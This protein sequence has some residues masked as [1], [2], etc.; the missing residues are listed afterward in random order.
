MLFIRNEI[1]FSKFSSCEYICH[2]YLQLEYMLY[3]YIDV[4]RH[5]SADLA[6]F[7]KVSALYT[8]FSRQSDKKNRTEPPVKP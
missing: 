4:C 1:R 7:P 6:P 5:V 2:I 8:F 3:L